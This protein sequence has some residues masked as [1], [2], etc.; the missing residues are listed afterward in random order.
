MSC[1]SG[2]MNYGGSCM[3]SVVLS[4]FPIC[5]TSWCLILCVKIFVLCNVWEKNFRINYKLTGMEVLGRKGVEEK[6]SFIAAY[7]LLFR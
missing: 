3:A 1:S 5:F 6:L 4:N 7:L 2:I